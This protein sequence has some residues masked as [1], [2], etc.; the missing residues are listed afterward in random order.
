MTA[1]RLLT[2]AIVLVVLALGGTVLEQIAKPVWTEARARQPALRLD[3]SMAAAG[4]GV[5]LALLGGFR[6]LVA[7]AVWVRMYVQWENHDL[8]GV[9]TLIRLVTAIDPRPVYFWLN[10]ARIVAY[11]LTSWRIMMAGGYDT[12]PEGVQTRIGHEQA[13]LAL[14]QLDAAMTFHPQNADLWIER[15]N[16]QLNRLGDPAAAA[17][18]YRRAYEQ[19]NAPYY[20]ARLHAELLKRLNRKKEALDW[21]KKVYAQ[22]PPNDE[23]AQPELILERIRELERDLNVPAEQVIRK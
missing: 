14:R 4:Q 9:E 16:I 20:A 8:P 11:D 17:E 10:G 1:A 6:A 5:T 15:A 13:G 23:S 7:D 3:S 21:L 2:L 12:T 22:L 19:P 18:S